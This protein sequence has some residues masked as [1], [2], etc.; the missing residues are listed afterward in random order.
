MNLANKTFINLKTN[1]FVKVIDSFDNIA[2]IEGG[3]KIDVRDL[4]N[5]NLYTEYID[6]SN[7][8]ESQKAYDDLFKKIKEIDTSKIKDDVEDIVPKIGN[9]INPT[10]SESAIIIS[11]EEEERN[12]LAK[13]Y[14]LYIDNQSSIQK[15][16]ELFA[17][18]LQEDD[19]ELKKTNSSIN[20]QKQVSYNKEY[21]Q[22]DQ[23]FNF[24]DPITSIF[25]NV[26]RNVDFKMNIEISNKIPRID[27]IEMMEDSYEIS[28]INFLA[29]E[30][31][32]NLLNNPEQIKK[33]I[34]DKIKELVYGSD[35]KTEK[36][37]RVRRSVQNPESNIE[38]KTK[39]T[40]STTKKK[41]SQND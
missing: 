21:N 9:D 12:E 25:R 4:L 41:E 39:S 31:T 7:F 3:N 6:P 2:I 18:I 27:F 16:N 14:G 34:I 40:K 35:L 15:Q 38:S 37:G 10:T 29:E 28:I 24:H 26:K 17:K 30:F 8:F 5:N 19:N 32:N 33:M 23:R 1:E 11:S 36:K 22:H 20:K 13:K